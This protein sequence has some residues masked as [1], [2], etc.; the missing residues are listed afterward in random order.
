MERKRTLTR[1]VSYA[2]AFALMALV[3]PL[4][5]HAQESRGRITGRVLDPTKATVS[6]A[7]VKIT[8]SARGATFNATT[9]NEGLFLV[10]YLLPGTYQ[11]AVEASIGLSSASPRRSR[12]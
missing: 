4:S 12:M 9:N 5:L 11:V 7:T 6:G 8:D 2:V 10:T 1:Y 3:L